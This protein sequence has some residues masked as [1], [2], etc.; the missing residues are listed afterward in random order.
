MLDRS[1]WRD[2]RSTRFPSTPL[3]KEVDVAIV[4][5]GVTGLT[6]AYLLKKS[7]KRVAVFERERIGAGETGNTSAH[8]TCI[9]DERITT[10]AS[11]FGDEGAR[12][13]WEGGLAAID[14]IESIAVEGGIE[15]GFRRVPGYLCAPFFATTPLDSDVAAIREDA[16]L[17]RRLGFDVRFAESGPITGFPALEM[18]D[19]ALFHP[20]EYLDG[21]ARAVDGDGSYV[22]EQCEVGSVIDDPFAVLVNG[23]TIACTDLVIA[24]HVPIVG[25]R[26]LVGA[27]LF[28]TK[29]YPYS[30]YVL[31]AHLPANAPRPGSYNDV[32]NPYYYLRIHDDER[33]SYA[34]FG[35]EDH[36]TG[37][38]DDV[39]AHVQRLEQRFMRLF[40]TATIE[41]RWT[42]QVVETDDGL[43]FIGKVAENQYVGTG[44]AG[45]GLTFGTLAG[46]MSHASIMGQPNPWT[47]LFDPHR[48]ASSLG[49]LKRLVLENTDYPRY[50]VADRLRKA[51]GGSESVKP[52]EGKVLTIGGKRVAVHRRD[53]GELVKVSAVCTHMGCLVRWNQGDRTWDCP[54]HG[55]R[56]TPEGLVLGGP[57]E[58][59]LEP[60][61]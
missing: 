40:P 13:A 46:I 59:P 2:A 29:L 28:Q 38:A 25:V 47:E 35:G 15:C 22:L 7:G 5:G 32:S 19:Q 48:K 60:A 58:S 31:G 52:G 27:T 24:T 8:L 37:Q 20:L 26:G 4:G 49:S 45:N 11:R 14:L 30:S 57:A 16:D 34:I 61:D 54:C 51:S 36:K 41:R 42:G 33:G 21:L 9:T 23:E 18:S 56:F 53:D 55:S 6:A 3:P 50:F 43:P 39:D 17:A 44:Y 10:L 1:I 12:L